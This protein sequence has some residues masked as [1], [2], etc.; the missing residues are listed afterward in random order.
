MMPVTKQVA[1][2]L[3]V[4]GVALAGCVDTAPA[5]IQA[6]RDAT[7]R[8]DP[9]EAI[10]MYE[11]VIDARDQPA[12]TRAAAYLGRGAT[13][14]EQGDKDKALAD[15]D[16]AIALKPDLFEAYISRAGVYIDKG[17]PPKA[18][19]D[20]DRALTLRPTA[21]EVYFWRGMVKAYLKRYGEAA[22][23]YTQ[24]IRVGFADA[25]VFEKRG[26]ANAMLGATDVAIA[27]YSRA[28]EINDSS[29]R[30]RGRSWPKF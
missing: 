28:I 19:A 13:Y 11:R 30:A 18:I 10:K 6:G 27:D 4:A 8:G 9:R 22:T 15:F 29:Q 14:S 17:Q 2:L 1:T 21:G 23:D 25:E 12:A 3:L 26:D 16:Q 24:A 7:E 5:D 20:Y